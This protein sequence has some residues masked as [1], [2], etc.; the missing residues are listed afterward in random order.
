MMPMTNLQAPPNEATGAGAVAVAK[1]S[2]AR[3]E[4]R[5]AGDIK[6]LD[7]EF[8]E[9]FTDDTRRVV[10]GRIFTLAE[11]T[12]TDAT[13][14]MP[15]PVVRIE[16]FSDAYFAVLRALP[17][18]ETYFTEFDNVVIGGE[19]LAVAL[20]ADGKDTLDDAQIAR[21]VLGFRGD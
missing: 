18:L 11:G 10:G 21:L 3:R 19:R 16:P 6:D 8:A 12:W 1:Q 5:S 4:A 2:A 17:E 20:A 13:K 9:R 15:G 7:E 14:E